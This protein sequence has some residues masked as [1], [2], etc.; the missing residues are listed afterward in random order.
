MPILSA[1]DLANLRAALADLLPDTCNIDRP[2][3]T[4][5]IAGGQSTALTSFATAVP[6]LVTSIRLRH[7]SGL[8]NDLL[9]TPED[10]RRMLESGRYNI[11]LPQD[12]LVELNDVVTVTTLDDLKLRIIT[13]IVGESL[14]VVKQCAGQLVSEED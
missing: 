4:D 8:G 14:E 7:S 5:D 1:T 2:T 3:I 11:T 12:V 10:P 13:V 6:V 9:G